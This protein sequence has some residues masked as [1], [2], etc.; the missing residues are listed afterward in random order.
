MENFDIA[1]PKTKDG[2]RIWRIFIRAVLTENDVLD[3]TQS[4]G[5]AHIARQI[6]AKLGPPLLNS[7]RIVYPEVRAILERDFRSEWERGSKKAARLI[8]RTLDDP[9][10]AELVAQDFDDAYKMMEHIRDLFE[11]PTST[12]VPLKPAAVS[13]GMKFFVYP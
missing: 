11:S 5:T 1:P 10:K 9:V 7:D 4:D 2:Y 8:A 12:Y 13:D 3:Y 6:N